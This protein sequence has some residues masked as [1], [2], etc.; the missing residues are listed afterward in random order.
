MAY[1]GNEPIIGQW[2]KL[3]DISSGF[4]GSTATFTTSVG[5]ANITAGTVNQLIISLGGVIQNPGVDYTVSTNSITFT[6][7]PASGL[8]FFGIYAGDTLNIGTPS[9]GTVNTAQ[10]VDGAVTSAKILDGTI[11]NV[12]INASAAIA[13]SKLSL[14]GSI[15]NA[16][17]NASAAI[18]GSKIQAAS[19]SNAGAVQLTD[20]TSST[21][22]TTAATP[23]SVKTSYDLANAALP[24]A[25]GTMTGDIALTNSRITQFKTATFNSQVNLVG[26]SGTINI[27]WSAAQNYRQPQP[28]STI[29][30]TFTNP[31]GPGHFQLFIDNTSTAQTINWPASVIFMGSTWSGTNSKRAVLNFWYDGSSTYLAIGTNQA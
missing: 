21:S 4:N 6:T 27:D 3:D 5:G 26:T 28:T 22:T 10:L 29:T 23:N 16:D 11:L 7:A 15:V 9:A 8:S 30:Y 1:I 20:S 12:D 24:K 13:Y 14:T 18:A 17:I 25:G 2:R 31:S 19:T